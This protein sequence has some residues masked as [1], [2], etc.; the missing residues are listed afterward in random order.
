MIVNWKYINLK[1]FKLKKKNISS[2]VRKLKTIN[3]IN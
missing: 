3:E 2:V 1:D